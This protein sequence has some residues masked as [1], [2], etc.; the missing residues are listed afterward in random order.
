MSPGAGLSVTGDQAGSSRNVVSPEQPEPVV[1][2]GRRQARRYG[3]ARLVDLCALEFQR[4]G[5]PQRI[6]LRNGKVAQG[7][8]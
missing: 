4:F 8:G 2:R 5:V 6:P 3:G 7:C 1:A